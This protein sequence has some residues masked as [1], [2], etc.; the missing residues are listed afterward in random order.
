MKDALTAK[1][2]E[3]SAYWQ[4][5]VQEARQDE[6]AKLA[7]SAQEGF[8]V[9]AR[10]RAK[11]TELEHQLASLCFFPVADRLAEFVR[12]KEAAS[13]AKF[14]K[15]QHALS[16]RVA[17]EAQRDRDE[18]ARLRAEVE[19]EKQRLVR[20]AAEIDEEKA[21]WHQEQRELSDAFSETVRPLALF[22]LGRYLAAYYLTSKGTKPLE[23]SLND[24]NGKLVISSLV[25]LRVGALSGFLCIET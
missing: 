6:R 11:V 13:D 1:L 10:T 25:N 24:L 9:A 22:D 19:L 18:V 14:T 20:R 8:R 4:N 17:D 12:Q 3:N 16:E 2:A 7:A 5:V 23:S 15:Q 21:A